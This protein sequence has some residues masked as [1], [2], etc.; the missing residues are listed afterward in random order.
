MEQTKVTLKIYKPLLQ[1]FNEQIDRLCLK[2]DAFLNHMLR[3]EIRRLRDELGTKRQSSAARRYI[4]GELKRL[5]THTINVVVDKDVACMLNEVVESSNLVRDAFAN[6]LMM[7]LRSSPKLLKYLELPSSTRQSDFN[8]VIDGSSTAPLAAME[9]IFGDPMYYLRS[10][11]EERFQEGL[12]M[13]GL[14]RQFIG[15]SCYLPD[16]LV[17]GTLEQK[18]AEEFSDELLRELEEMESLA[19]DAPSSTASIGVIK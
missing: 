10:A 5:G 15:F 2:R 18:E 3:T 19:F 1:A 12:Y 13:L 7:F 6:R 17:P 8:S 16:S 14:P 11:A 9:E 4:S